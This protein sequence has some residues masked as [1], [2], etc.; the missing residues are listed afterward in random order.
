L[1][2]SFLSR[3]VYLGIPFYEKR[4]PIDF[5]SG[6]ERYK[7]RIREQITQEATEKVTSSALAEVSKLFEAAPYGGAGGIIKTGTGSGKITPSPG[8]GYKGGTSPAAQAILSAAAKAKKQSL[9][10]S[11]TKRK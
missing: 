9:N 6:F 11:T 7:A 10:K 4:K 2:E 3:R 1:P 8:A 5:I